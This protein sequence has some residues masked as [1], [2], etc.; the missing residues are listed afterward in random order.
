MMLDRLTMPGDG[1]AP[2]AVDDPGG[3][4][5]ADPRT[6]AE[7]DLSALWQRLRDD[8]PVF[9]HGGTED[10]PGF[11]VLTRYADVYELHRDQRF[12]SQRGNVL[13]TLL[14]GGDSAAGSMLPVTDGPRHRQLRRLMLSA[15]GPRALAVIGEQVRRTAGQLLRDA[16]DA[17]T[18]DFATDVSARIP[19]ATI[20]DLLGVPEADRALILDLTSQTLGS[21]LAG[22]PDE[23]AWLAKNELLLYFAELAATRRDTPHSDVVSL[24]ATG[25]IDG[26]ALTDA[27]VVLNCYSLIL[28][29]DETTRL[30]MSGGVL[31]L[32][33]HPDQWRALREGSVTLESAVEEMLRWTSATAHLG[34]TAVGDIELHGQRIAA[35]DVVTGWTCSANRD[36]RAFDDPDRFDLARFDLARSPNR[37]LT[38]GHGPHFC[39]GAHLARVEI[40]ALLEELRTLVAAVQPAGPP[41]YFYSNF[42]TGVSSLPVT[43]EAA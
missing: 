28:G 18:V 31:A 12:S 41:R 40:G 19:L 35:G 6:H 37:H 14:A 30:T 20:C 2:V 38:F 27:E 11:W 24:L 7:Y 15:F 22:R 36:P 10:R 25:E 34:R 3:V 42:L 39:L 8:H 5:L 21:E 9:W 43:L 17:G 33:Q 32:M 1:R 26:M 29:G 13:D 23:D 4:D 16:L